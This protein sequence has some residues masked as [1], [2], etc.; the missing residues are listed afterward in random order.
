MSI[1]S[2]Q[3]KD[4]ILALFIR[5]DGERFLLGDDGYDFKDS[6]LHFV[7]NTIENDEVAKQG[8]DGTLLAGQVRRSAI[9][10]FDGYVGDATVTKEAIE[11][12]RRDFIAFFMKGHHFRVVYVDCARNAWQRKGGYLVDAP[13]VKE[14]WQIHPEYH[15]ALNFEDVN[16]Y[17]Y[18][19]NADGDEIL[20]IVQS[21]PISSEVEGGLEWDANGA[22]SEA[23]Q[24][25]NETKSVN[26]SNIH[27]TD[28]VVAPFASVQIDGNT[29]QQTY[30]GKNL[31]TTANVDATTRNGVTLSYDAN[32]QIITLNGTCDTDNS[33]FAFI[34][35][36][37]GLVLNGTYT[38]SCVYV[39]GTITPTGTNKIQ[40]ASEGWAKLLTQDITN[41]ISSITKTV[42]F[43][44]ARATIRCDSGT[45]FT[46]YKFKIQLEKNGSRTDWEPF[47]G[48]TPAPNP[49]Y[50]QAVQTVTGENVVRICGKNLFIPPNGD[51]VAGVTF[52]RNQDGTY[53][54]S[55]T[56]TARAQIVYYDDAPQLENGETYTIKANQFLGDVI[57]RAE[58]FN[59]ETY[60]R[61]NYLLNSTTQQQTGVWNGTNSN[62]CCFVLR[63]ES[64]KTVNVTG[65]GIQLEK[66]S[67]ATTY[68]AYQGQDYEINLG[69][70]IID[71]DFADQTG[72]GVTK[73]LNA[74]GSITLNGHTTAG[75]SFTFSNDFI[76]EAGQ[77]YTLSVEILSG[78]FV[79]Y[80]LNQNWAIQV[81]LTDPNASPP[82]VSANPLTTSGIN[83]QY[84]SQTRR[85]L[86]GTFWFGYNSSTTSE[87]AIF[88]NF[89][90]R[91]QIEQGSQATSY[92]QYYTPIELCKIGTYQ[93]YIYR[94][95]G[96]W[97]IHK[98][99]GKFAFPNTGWA[100][101][102]DAPITDG[103][104][105][106][107]SNYISGEFAT[108]SAGY[109][110]HF[111]VVSSG[112]VIGTMRFIDTDT[113]GYNVSISNSDTGVSSSDSWDTKAAKFNAWCASNNPV[114]Y[115]I[116]T[117]P[118]DTE[119]TNSALLA[120][121]NNL[122][123]GG[124]LAGI[125][126]IAIMPAA[127]NETGTL[128]IQYYTKYSPVPIGG[129]YVWEEGGTGGPT[130]VINESIAEV[131]P[132]WTVPG[133]ALNPTLENATTGEQI[134]FVGMVGEGQ[135]LIVDMGA[136]TASLNGLNVI[137]SMA[138][139]FIS[140]QVGKNTLLYSAS[141]DA[142]ASEIGWS[143]IV[144]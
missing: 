40:L 120:Q 140:L 119:I 28:A 22:I 89:T 136:Q 38:L 43:T 67:T 2:V 61:T 56:A 18:D 122:K 128:E 11:Q 21:V 84:T 12:M 13:E 20:A 34:T 116:K 6:Q 3:P 113:F 30:T 82:T 32:T 58:A 118:T 65:L 98:A 50:P 96:K 79:P 33:S 138:G 126:N 37:N 111:R 42:D 143:P 90:F 31:V 129:G 125:N 102:T 48:R 17:V 114:C 97:Y 52:T 8:T 26:G 112:N 135:T 71:V 72:N 115:Y 109:S 7:G 36:N 57:V 35:G 41:S 134:E 101:R 53:D 27:V 69:K 92:A 100:P 63:V 133:P 83:V 5:D 141:G 81:N 127:G 108:G 80:N 4:F 59:G 110:S 88:D 103:Q 60:L 106:R 23:A 54:I 73:T 49:D 77:T 87:M 78:S 39:S 25:D 95:G 137:S 117:T 93:D 10:S 9:Q 130:T 104:V 105:F 45:K 66:G 75:H 107:Y 91:V 131:Y 51:E 29:S 142:G 62:R 64:G 124:T 55:G 70:N 47:V 44:V 86:R 76:V 15:V 1:V 68:Q 121:L 85:T 16:Y 139:E 132:V 46:N 123:A 144:G 74:D 99:V 19:E 94:D 24:M 14:L